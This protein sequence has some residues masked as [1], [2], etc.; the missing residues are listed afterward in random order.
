MVIPKALRAELLQKTHASHLGFDAMCRRARDSLFWPGLKNDI[1][2]M[3]AACDA[4]QT[5]RPAQWREPLIG[6]PVPTRPWQVIH[7]DIFTWDNCL[8]LV[9]VDGF[10]DFF[11]INRLGRDTTSANL[12]KKT[13]VLSGRYGRPDEFHTDSDPRY[14]TAGFK[15][16]QQKWQTEHR[17]SSPHH[18]QSNGKS[19]S[20]VKAAKRLIKKCKHADQCLQEALLEWRLTPQVEGLSPAEKF[21]GRKL[22][23][24]IPTKLETLATKDSDRVTKNITCRRKRQLR[25][26]NKG[27]RPLPPL[28]AG[29]SVRIQP[30]DYSHEWQPGLCI[31]RMNQRTYRVKTHDG[32]QLIRN[33]RYLADVPT[34]N[35]ET[36]ALPIAHRS[37][38]RNRETQQPAPASSSGQPE[39]GPS[40]RSGDRTI[41]ER[42]AIR[43]RAA[44]TP[45]KAPNT[46]RRRVEGQI[47]VGLKPGANTRRLREKTRKPTSAPNKVQTETRRSPGEQNTTKHRKGKPAGTP[48]TTE[49]T[50]MD[51]SINGTA[52]T[53]SNSRTSRRERPILTPA[54]LKL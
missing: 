15:K 5:Y 38:S 26:Y 17:V 3:A 52:I 42:L 34:N 37:P 22:A 35:Q 2:N 51:I 4:C 6:K 33:R 40:Q 25:S 16:F 54:R 23:S 46:R 53:G 28:S 39:K 9:T 48:R 13:E 47:G 45:A 41:G 29:Q 27:T 44:N 12:I 11:E 50:P 19:Q 10:S 7:Q 30:T 8:Y 20:G 21:F 36:N 18:H 24:T 1:K 49:P 31:E 14:L 43:K 32:T